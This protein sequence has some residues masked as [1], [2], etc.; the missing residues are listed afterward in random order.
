MATTRQRRRALVATAALV[1][2]SVAALSIALL[3]RSGFFDSPERTGVSTGGDGAVPL[4]TLGNAQAPDGVYGDAAGGGAVAD[5]A[6]GATY[7]V[8]GADGSLLPVSAAPAGAVTWNNGWPQAVPVT[9]APTTATTAATGD[10]TT[11]T[12]PSG[13]T[14]TTAGS[15]PTTTAGPEATTTTEA[16]TTTTTEAPTTTTAPPVV[17]SGC[18][19]SGFHITVCLENGGLKLVRA[20]TSPLTCKKASTSEVECGKS[21][22]ATEIKFK[23][24]SGSIRVEHFPTSVACVPGQDRFDCVQLAGQGEAAPRPANAFIEVWALSK[25]SVQAS[26]APA[27]CSVSKEFTCNG[28]RFKSDGE[29]DYYALQVRYTL[30]AMVECGAYPDATRQAVVIRCGAR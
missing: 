11:T 23:L 16:P 18:D 22:T 10:T 7:A 17:R 21:D 13:A 24:E 2:C 28:I 3:D 15:G 4:V 20:D 26:F 5:P 29:D 1:S 27:G 12:A 19:P 14:T 9:T 30:A 8:V 6:A 25:K